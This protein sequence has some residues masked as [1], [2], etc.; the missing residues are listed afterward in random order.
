MPLTEKAEAAVDE[1]EEQVQRSEW[2]GLRSTSGSPIYTL[3]E[4]AEAVIREI[5]KEIE[6][7]EGNAGSKE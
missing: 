3:R 2:S 5:R 4:I 1:L 7:L 6:E